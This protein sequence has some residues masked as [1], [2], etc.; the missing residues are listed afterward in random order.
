MLDCLITYHLLTFGGILMM[1]YMNKIKKFKS[2]SFKKCSN[3]TSKLPFFKYDLVAFSLNSSLSTWI[4]G[5]IKMY[6]IFSQFF[7]SI[8]EGAIFCC[9]QHLWDAKKFRVLF[10]CRQHFCSDL[11]LKEA[12]KCSDLNQNHIF[13]KWLSWF[14]WTIKKIK[15]LTFVTK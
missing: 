6:L 3:I 8:T 15:R 13:L 7:A 12:K 4:I 5:E 2:P 11:N 14:K 1:T 10:W 9:L